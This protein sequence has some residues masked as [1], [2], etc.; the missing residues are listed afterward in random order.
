[1][2]FRVLAFC[3][4]Y[5]NTNMHYKYKYAMPY[6]T[7]IGSPLQKGQKQPEG[8]FGATFKLLKIVF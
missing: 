2:L 8:L 4:T 5:Q 6:G 7:K 1:M 3:T